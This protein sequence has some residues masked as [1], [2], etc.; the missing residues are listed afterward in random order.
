MNPPIARRPDCAE[1]CYRDAAT[2]ESPPPKL[3]FAD[4]NPVDDPLELGSVADLQ[5]VERS[6][7]PVEHA[8]RVRR[9]ERVDRILEDSGHWRGEPR[10]S[11]CNSRPR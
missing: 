11:I 7:H 5:R 9:S 1:S 6:V 4:V 2:T 8:D 3:T 10:P